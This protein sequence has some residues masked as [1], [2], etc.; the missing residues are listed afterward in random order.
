MAFFGIIGFAL[1]YALS[2][3]KEIKDPF[4]ATIVA[5]LCAASVGLL[6]N[7]IYIDV[8]EASKVAYTFWIMV[9]ILVATVKLA[10]SK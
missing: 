6:V 8:F 10:K 7:A 3:F 5:A 9:A 4:Y 2:G 1:W